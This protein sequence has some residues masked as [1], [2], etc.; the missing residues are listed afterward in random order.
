MLLCIQWMNGVGDATYACLHSLAISTQFNRWKALYLM[1][2]VRYY[3][4]MVVVACNG[5]YPSGLYILEHL[6]LFQRKLLSGV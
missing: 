1:E 2:I 3:Y 5:I 4:I 6:P